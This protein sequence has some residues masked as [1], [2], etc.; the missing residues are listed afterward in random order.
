MSKAITY[1][2]ILATVPF[3]SGSQAHDFY[4]LS[5]LPADVAERVVELEMY[6]DRFEP[7]I[8]AI[9]AEATKPYWAPTDCGLLEQDDA[10]AEPQS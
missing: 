6:G 9:L 4:D 2:A 10:I 7:A 3:Q 1:D 5:L 8:R